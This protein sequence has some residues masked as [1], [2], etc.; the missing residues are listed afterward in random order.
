MFPDKVLRFSPYEK[1]QPDSVAVSLSIRYQ[2]LQ[3]KI[4]GSMDIFKVI[5]EEGPLLLVNLL[6]SSYQK[7]S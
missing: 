2:S 3:T 4:D 5:K 6:M 7:I 1:E